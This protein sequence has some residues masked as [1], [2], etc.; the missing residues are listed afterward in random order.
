MT[1]VATHKY[2]INFIDVLIAIFSSQKIMHQ[3]H[4]ILA[5]AILTKFYFL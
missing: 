5:Q 4:H 1:T 3:N 2:L